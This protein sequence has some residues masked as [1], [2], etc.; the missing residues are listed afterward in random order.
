MAKGVACPAL[1]PGAFVCKKTI[2]VNEKGHDARG[3][4]V[5]DKKAHPACFKI[6]DDTV[7]EGLTLTGKTLHKRELF[8]SEV[9]AY[10]ARERQPRGPPLALEPGG[11]MLDEL[12][13]WCYVVQPVASPGLE[14]VWS[15]ADVFA[16]HTAFSVYE[17]S[18]PGPV[19]VAVVPLLGREL[20]SRTIFLDEWWDTYGSKHAP[21]F[22]ASMFGFSCP[23]SMRRFFNVFFASTASVELKR[24]ASLGLSMYEVYALALWRMRCAMPRRGLCPPSRAARSQPLSARCAPIPC[25]CPPAGRDWT[26]STSRPSWARTAHTLPG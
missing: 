10:V 20:T 25:S 3:H 18:V 26:T 4:F 24:T 12:A 23:A 21:G 19:P 15:Y 8:G 1:F 17:Q 16:A 2:E 6:G 9:V 14:E 22:H 13:S 7:A 5:F 11:E